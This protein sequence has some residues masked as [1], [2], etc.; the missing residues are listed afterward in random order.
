MSVAWHA[1]TIFEP[2]KF[3]Q[4]D[5]DQWCRHAGNVII[6]SYKHSKEF[7]RNTCKLV[8]GYPNI[9]YVISILAIVMNKL[10]DTQTHVTSILAFVTNT[11]Y[12]TQT[13]VIRILTYTCCEHFG[14]FPDTYN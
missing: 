13:H 8:G 9:T 2:S 4:I 1:E 12:D 10:E 6:V 7:G 3:K 5:D 11:L 14:G